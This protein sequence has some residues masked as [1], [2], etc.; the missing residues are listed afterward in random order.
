[1]DNLITKIVN[2]TEEHAGKPIRER[3]K[4]A[5]SSLLLN[6]GTNEEVDGKKY[7]SIVGKLM[8]AVSK[9]MIEG[10]NAALALSK[11]FKLP[12]KEHWDSLIYFV[13]YIKREKDSIKLTIRAPRE[14]RFI[15][16]VDGK[17]APDLDERQSV[18]GIINILGGSIIGWTSKFQG[19]TA[20]ST[21]EAEYYATTLGF[22]DLLFIQNILRELGEIV[23]PVYIFS[24]NSSA[25]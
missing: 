14:M 25:I 2:I 23:E 1:M 8:Y 10:T 22:Q 12:Q 21:T 5:P 16:D 24:D 7:C 4:L 19:K 20:L 6:K 11:N 9:L 17:F 18:S 15:S 3:S 13:G